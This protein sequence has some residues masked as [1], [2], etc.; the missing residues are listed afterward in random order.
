[1]DIYSPT[2]ESVMRSVIFL[3]LC[4]N[5]LIPVHGASSGWQTAKHLQAELISEYRQVS[6]GQQLQ[7]QDREKIGGYGVKRYRVGFA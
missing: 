2:V 4:C 3:L 1:M 7:L 6:A 5:L